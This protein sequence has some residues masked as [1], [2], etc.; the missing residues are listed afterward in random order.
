MA[1]REDKG[2]RYFVLK[3]QAGVEYKIRYSF[4]DGK[5]R[6]RGTYFSLNPQFGTPTIFDGEYTPRAVTRK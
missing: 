4:K 2:T 5:L 1:L 3:G 6:L